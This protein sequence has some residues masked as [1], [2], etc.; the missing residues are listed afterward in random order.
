LGEHL[1][2]NCLSR[3]RSMA[4]V[5]GAI[6]DRVSR[7]VLAHPGD[8]VGLT[9][10]KLATKAGASVATVSRF[11]TGLGYENYRAFQ[12]D[13]AAS[14]AANEAAVSDVFGPGDK[15]ATIVERV[16]EMNRQSLL[17]TEALLEREKVN[18]VAKLLMRARRL[19]LIGIGDSGLIAK[20]AALRFGSLA[21]A[22]HA[23]T[24]P[25]EGVLLLSSATSRDVA[26]GISHTGRTAVTTNLLQLA[27]RKRART[28]GIT[29]YADSTLAA[30]SEFTLL[31][32]FRERRVN[33]AVSSSAIA[34]MC[35]LDA[36]YFLIAYYQ[37]AKAQDLASEIERVA[38]DSLR[39]K[40]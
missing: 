40:A 22:T 25:Y 28:I 17:D 32:S 27:Q 2:G 23:I 36:I 11:C 16:F 30:L 12:I 20:S 26:V 18:A 10:S 4:R 7:F 39:A 31:T 13:L 15:P 35:L 14:L 37:G 34:Q 19:F 3:I 1:K 21:I 8:A 33:A 9:I 6:T 24:D 5:E 29:N 38:E